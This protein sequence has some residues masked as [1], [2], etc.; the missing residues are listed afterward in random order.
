MADPTPPTRSYKDCNL[1]EC[2]TACNHTKHRKQWERQRLL[3]LINT[4]FSFLP[5]NSCHGSFNNSIEKLQLVTNYFRLIF[6]Q[7]IHNVSF[8]KDQA[9]SILV[10][11]M[12]ESQSN[13]ICASVELTGNVPGIFF[14]TLND[15]QVQVTGNLVNNLLLDGSADVPSI[16]I[17]GKFKIKGT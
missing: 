2:T 16:Q 1:V 7:L 6:Q 9:L 8:S 17:C 13:C 10:E 12:S 4:L 14:S 11:G 5:F 15:L 3:V